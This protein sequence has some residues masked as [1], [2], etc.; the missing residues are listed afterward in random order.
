M[1]RTKAYTPSGLLAATGAMLAWSFGITIIKLTDS[2]FLI[3]SFYR[4]VFALPLLVIAWRVSRDRTL[5][6]RTAGFGGVLFGLHQV[7]HFS[8]LRY[9]TAAVVTILFALQPVVVGALGYRVTGERTTTRFYLWAGVAIVG[10]AVLVLASVDQPEA[11]PLGTLL[12]VINL[13]IWSAYFLA[14]KRAR[15]R[16]GTTSWL[17]VMTAVS[18][19]F[20]ALLS[21]GFRQPFGAPDGTEWLYLALIGIVP[22]TIGHFLITWAHPRIHAAASSTVILGV[23]VVASISTAVFVGEAFGPMHVTG[24]VIA[25]VGAGAAIRHLPAPAHHEAA[26]TYGEAVT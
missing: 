24:A 22:A 4:H 26:E 18:G 7:A 21:V 12:A 5:P 8:A 14:T 9:S 20:I 2:P 15:E 11:T 19:A 6:W 10:C 3:A 16:V 25:L 13:G 17:L 23:P 1:Q